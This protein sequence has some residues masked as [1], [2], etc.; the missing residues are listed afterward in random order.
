MKLIKKVAGCIVTPATTAMGDSKID[1][2][3][4]KNDRYSYPYNT[5]DYRKNSR[6]S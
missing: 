4:V 5:L 3:G 2:K 1:F 6:D